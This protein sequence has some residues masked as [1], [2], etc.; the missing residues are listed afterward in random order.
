MFLFGNKS[1]FMPLP[2]LKV[3]WVC[4]VLVAMVPLLVAIFYGFS[5][6][7]HHNRAQRELV[8]ISARVAE[9]GATLTDQAK[10][11]ERVSRQF[12]VLK[13]ERLQQVF[14]QKLTEL[15]DIARQLQAL[16]FDDALQNTLHQLLDPLP[17][18]EKLLFDPEPDGEQIT[19]LFQ[20]VHQ[21]TKFI[22]LKSAHWV[23]GQ[24]DQLAASYRESQWRLLVIGLWALP[25]TLVLMWLVSFMVLRPIYQLSAAIRRMGQGDWRTDIQIRGSNEMVL[26][27]DNL[28]WMQDQLLT[29]EAQKHTFLQQVTHELKTPLAAI[30]EAGSLLADEVPGRLSGSQRQ[31][32]TI[33]QSNAE[34]LRGLIQQLLDYNSV[35]K[36]QTQQI[37]NL[38]V[39]AF[40]KDKLLDFQGLAE[41]RKVALNLQGDSLH[42]MLDVIRVGMILRN[43]VSNAVELTPSGKAVW[44]AWGAEANTW[45][46]QVMD[47]GPGIDLQE[48]NRLFEPF[49]QG[50]AKRQGSV[51]G[52]GI[53]LAI[54]KECSEFL[55]A[56]IEVKNIAG[57]GACFTVRFPLVIAQPEATG[58]HEL[59]PVSP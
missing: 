57:K 14:S 50:G 32:L 5:V 40:I 20:Q 17:Q 43:L 55:A 22:N 21:H 38:D 1:S 47:E 52:N 46:L 35:I 48:K 9:L 4:G 42:L 37:K 33:L 36:D 28:R 45:W 58:S 53:G 10:D 41:T 18:I 34:H 12:L 44:V 59:L 2:S 54:V 6:M 29:L 11:L 51:K 15:Q 39:K 25:G 7:D 24:L 13:D 49:Y 3:Q 26:L 16:P 23:Q 27:G 31:V 19:L 8:L 30:M 56:D